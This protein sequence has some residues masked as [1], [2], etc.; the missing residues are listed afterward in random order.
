MYVCVR[1]VN[2]KVPDEKLIIVQQLMSK[3]LG[4][5]VSYCTLTRMTGFQGCQEI[6]STVH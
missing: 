5:R 1:S 4:T 6:T 2:L 3:C